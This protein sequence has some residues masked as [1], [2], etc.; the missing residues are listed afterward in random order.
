MN[1]IPGANAVAPSSPSSSATSNPWMKL[2]RDAY[3]RSTTFFDNNLRKR[4]EDDLRMFNS[5]HPKDSKYYS[6]SYKYRSKF[7]RPKSRSVLRK[8]EAT[9]AL[10][11]FSNPDATSI[12][13]AN[14]SDMMQVI[15]SSFW[16]EIIQYRLTTSIPWFL[17]VIGGFQDAMKVGLVVSYQHWRYREKEVE[18]EGFDPLTGETYKIKVPKVVED[19]PCIQLFPIDRV[20]F[21]PG[22]QWYDIAGTSPYLI[23]EWPMYVNDVLEKMDNNGRA[24]PWKK[25]DKNTILP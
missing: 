16:K 3:Q 22:A 19:R 13:P 9:A 2:A 6:D 23:L 1:P 17:T 7:F 21:D 25:Y 24:A 11:F 18:Q 15:S 8:N 20:R 12:E 14:P 4:V 5:Q 10:A